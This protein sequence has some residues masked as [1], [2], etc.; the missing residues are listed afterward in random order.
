MSTDL[1]HRYQEIQAQIELLEREI[2]IAITEYQTVDH[3][4]TMLNVMAIM[5]QHAQLELEMVSNALLGAS[6]PSLKIMN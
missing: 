3:R 2:G 4:N 1:T 5:L 6:G